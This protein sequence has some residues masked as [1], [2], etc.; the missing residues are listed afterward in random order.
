MPVYSTKAQQ[1]RNPYNAMTP[2]QVKPTFSHKA[3]GERRGGSKAL[4]GGLKVGLTMLGTAIGGPLGAAVGAGL[5]EGIDKAV[6]QKS[7]RKMGT[8]SQLVGG[9]KRAS[10]VES[11]GGI[12]KDIG[13]SMIQGYMGAATGG[14]GTD[15]MSGLLGKGEGGQKLLQGLSKTEFGSKALQSSDVGKA[16]EIAGMGPPTMEQFDAQ[17]AMSMDEKTQAG[18]KGIFGKIKGQGDIQ[19]LLGQTAEGNTNLDMDKLKG[20]FSNINIGGTQ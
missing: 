12:V 3:T 13:G 17:S 5:G 4:M 14:A 6:T 1:G 20:L 2:Q 9:E 11:A 18:L 15:Q 19:S 16:G 10:Q 7:L 8:S